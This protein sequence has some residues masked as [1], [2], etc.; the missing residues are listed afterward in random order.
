RASSGLA[1]TLLRWSQPAAA[2][3]GRPRLAPA[4]AL[5]QALH[6]IPSRGVPPMKPLHILRHILH[7]IALPLA[8]ALAA[9]SSFALGEAGRAELAD[10][11]GRLAVIQYGLP[12]PQR[13]ASFA[14]LAE[15]AGKAVAA[16]PDAAELHIW[17]GIIL[18]TWAG[19]K[20]GLGALDLVKQAK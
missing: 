13:E 8:I 2:T 1:G 10:L 20:G 19:A 18:S 11:H 16:E 14:E 4:T 3:S 15:R 7:R 5:H 6:P 12:D 9:P 17:H